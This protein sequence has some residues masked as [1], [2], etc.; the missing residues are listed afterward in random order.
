MPGL[1]PGSKRL[2]V[3]SKAD[4]RQFAVTCFCNDGFNFSRL[5]EQDAIALNDGALQPDQWQRTEHAF[6]ETGSRKEFSYTARVDNFIGSLT[7]KGRSHYQGHC[8]TTVEAVAPAS[9]AA[10]VD[11]F[12]RSIWDVRDVATAPSAPAAPNGSAESRL[13]TIKELL[14][15]KV[16]TQQEYDE[17]RHAILGSL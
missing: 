3:R 8:G 2:V 17:R 13:A 1:P 15:R 6:R 14:D 16:I 11:G 5:R 4:Y 7:R 9:D 12:I 10:S